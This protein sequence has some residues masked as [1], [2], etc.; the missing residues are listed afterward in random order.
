MWHWPI[1]ASNCHVKSLLSITTQNQGNHSEGLTAG[2]GR[3]IQAGGVEC[4]TPGQSCSQTVVNGVRSPAASPG[5]SSQ[6][7]SASQ[8]SQGIVNEGYGPGQAS[9]NKSPFYNAGVM[10]TGKSRHR[11]YRCL[12]ELS[13]HRLGFMDPLQQDMLTWMPTDASSDI[14][15]ADV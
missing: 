12:C 14:A 15:Q 6:P 3:N 4:N 8:Q 2:G 10:C 7:G 11:P 1:D 13:L 9:A 5:Q